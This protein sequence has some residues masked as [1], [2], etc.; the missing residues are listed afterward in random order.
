MNKDEAK[1]EAWELVNQYVTAC[2]EMDENRLSDEQARKATLLVGWFADALLG[3]VKRERRETMA[4][5]G[6]DEHGNGLRSIGEHMGK[7]IN[8]CHD[9]Y[10]DL[11]GALIDMRRTGEADAVC[12]NTIRR[13]QTRFCDLVN[14]IKSES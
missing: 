12:L 3:A 5:L 10:Y 13:V 7:P 2:S 8:L 11:E 9:P 4:L 14:R 1:R 6:Y